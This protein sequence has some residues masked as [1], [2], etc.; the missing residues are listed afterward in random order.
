MTQRSVGQADVLSAG[1][2]L[3]SKHEEAAMR[4]GRLLLATAVAS[5]MLLSQP[6]AK[7]SDEP[8]RSL[9]GVWRIVEVTYT[10]AAQPPLRNPEPSQI[11]YTKSHYSFI[12]INQPR[13]P[14][15]RPVSPGKLTDAEKIARYEHWFRVTAHSGTYEFKD[16]VVRTRAVVAKNDAVMQGVEEFQVRGES[17]LVLLVAPQWGYTLK[18]KRI[19]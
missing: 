11:I 18:L 6:S 9:E 14:L 1:V 15:E 12:G 13:T 16:G 5:S 2:E 3:T 10:D 8:V 4:R 7:T 17:G 19:E